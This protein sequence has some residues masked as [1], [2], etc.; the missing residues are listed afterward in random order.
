MHFK[1][2]EAPDSRTAMK[3]VKEQLG[4]DAVILSNKTVH[5]GTPYQRV[6]VV[7]AM[8]YDLESITVTNAHPASSHG[9][10]PNIAPQAPGNPREKWAAPP[11]GTRHKRPRLIKS[12]KY[13]AVQ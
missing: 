7:A 10:E 8:D 3:M 2:F 11:Q 13:K 4:D 12:S 9:K 6:E 1:R 5:K